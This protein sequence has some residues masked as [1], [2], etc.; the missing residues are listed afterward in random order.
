MINSKKCIPFLLIFIML[1]AAIFTACGTQDEQPGQHVD[2]ETN[3]EITEEEMQAKTKESN[4]ISNGKFS[5]TVPDSWEGKYTLI[6]DDESIQLYQKAAYES[7][8]GGHLCSF[9]VFEDSSYTEI[10]CYDV[11]LRDGLDEQTYIVMYPSDVQADLDNEE[12]TSEYC[13]MTDELPEIVKSF[14]LEQ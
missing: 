1:S 13:K 4:K 6:M 9:V 8:G 14:V 11:I 2:S 3:N 12:S 5:I 10:P 7:F